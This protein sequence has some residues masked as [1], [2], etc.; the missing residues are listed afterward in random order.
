ML[1][2]IGKVGDRARLVPVH[3]DRQRRVGKSSPCTASPRG[4]PLR[5]SLSPQRRHRRGDPERHVLPARSA[6]E[7]ARSR[8]R[9]ADRR[10]APYWCGRPGVGGRRASSETHHSK[11]SPRMLALASASPDS[12]LRWI[13]AV[14]QQRC[15][16]LERATALEQRE[17]RES[18][19]SLDCRGSCAPGGRL[20]D[21]VRGRSVAI[22]RSSKERKAG[23]MPGM[24]IPL[25]ADKLD[26]WEAWV[27][28]LNGPRKRSCRSTRLRAPGLRSSRS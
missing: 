3:R 9:L 26:A 4:L 25:A 1:A 6:P 16:G 2:L 13:E 17:T 19:P 10:I 24:A 23:N 20:D 11:T 5:R 8:G 21:R 22:R 18:A 28:E 15:S 7:A 12:A 14:T 27:A